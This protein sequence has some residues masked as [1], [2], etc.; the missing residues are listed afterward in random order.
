VYRL[1]IDPNNPDILYV[2]IRAT[3]GQSVSD[4]VGVYKTTDGGES[5]TKANQ[6][7]ELPDV[8]ALVIDPSDS[9]TLYTG[10]NQHYTQPSGPLH[11]GGVYKSVDGGKNWQAVLADDYPLSALRI[12]SLAISPVNPDLIFAGSF[13]HSFHDVC[14]GA[15]I[16]ISRDAGK[17]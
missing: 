14:P 17:T 11:L 5:W 10:T 12:G 16:F 3:P 2:G 7:I 9:N 4:Y 15:G 6:N 8:W 1:V 13:D